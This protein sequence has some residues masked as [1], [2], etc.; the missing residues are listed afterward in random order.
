LLAGLRVEDARRPGPP[1][2]R[3]AFLREIGLLLALTAVAWLASSGFD[4]LFGRDGEVDVVLLGLVAVPLAVAGLLALGRRRLPHDLL[5]RTRVVAQ[6]VV[7][8]PAVARP[9]RRATRATGPSTA[10][11][12]RG[13]QPA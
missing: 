2:F 12:D 5:L 3:L 10:P 7:L 11:G 1:L 6:R 9:A 8:G 4:L 13:A